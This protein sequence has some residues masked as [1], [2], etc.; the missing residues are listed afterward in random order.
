MT[1][2]A[3]AYTIKK[4]LWAG[5][6]LPGSS[7]GGSDKHDAHRY[8]CH[9]GKLRVVYPTAKVAALVLATTTYQFKTVS[10]DQQICNKDRFIQKKKTLKV[11]LCLKDI[12]RIGRKRKKSIDN[13]KK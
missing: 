11:S 5:C 2:L 1:D 6:M 7:I 13:Y 9:L 3:F 10:K 4:G 12:C 8:L